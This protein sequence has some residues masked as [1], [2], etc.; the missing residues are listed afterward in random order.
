MP[1]DP[2]LNDLLRP[3]WP[4]LLKVSQHLK[5]ALPVGDQVFKFTSLWDRT[6]ENGESKSSVTCTVTAAFQLSSSR[7]WQESSGIDK[8]RG[9]RNVTRSW[10]QVS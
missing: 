9:A 5:A 3:T 10:E 8:V 7:W 1:Q 6:P 4:H 2:R